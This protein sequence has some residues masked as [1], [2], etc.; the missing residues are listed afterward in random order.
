VSDIKIISENVR[1]IVELLSMELLSMKINYTVI[2]F[3]KDNNQPWM[4]HTKADSPQAAARASIQKMFKSN[5]GGVPLEDIIVVEVIEG[6]VKG[7]LCNEKI[8]N[9]DDLR[10]VEKV[11]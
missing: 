10:P 9:A 11:G 5:D 6:H 4:D 3:Y 2:G 7:C 8:V 1:H